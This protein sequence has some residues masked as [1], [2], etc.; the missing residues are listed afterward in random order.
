MATTPPVNNAPAYNPM[1]TT[2]EPAPMQRRRCCLQP[3]RPLSTC[4]KIS[5]LV[6]CVFAAAGAIFSKLA[7]AAG[8]RQA[9]AHYGLGAALTFGAGA[10][11]AFYLKRS[12]CSHVGTEHLLADQ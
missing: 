9:K 2:D 8:S 3:T 11:A 12:F 5:L 10:Y 1:A 7:S 4:E 6:P